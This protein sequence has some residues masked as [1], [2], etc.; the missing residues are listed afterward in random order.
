MKTLILV[1]TLITTFTSCSKSQSAEITISKTCLAELISS[2]DEIECFAYYF[3]ITPNIIKANVNHYRVLYS[4][5]LKDAGWNPTNLNNLINFRVPFDNLGNIISYST[6]KK[7][8]K[9]DHSTHEKT[10]FD[11]YDELGY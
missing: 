10:L 7:Y 6:F 2:D 5:E 3:D 1:L 9:V 4:T 11:Y 8:M